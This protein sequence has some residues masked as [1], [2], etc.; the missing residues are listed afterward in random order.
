[1]RMKGW[2]MGAWLMGI[3]AGIAGAESLQTVHLKDYLNR[4]WA[5]ELISY[6]L[7][8]TLAGAK[9]IQVKDETGAALPCQVHNARVYL[10]VTLLPN[11]EKTFTISAGHPPPPPAKP[12]TVK[13]ENGLLVLDSGAMAVRL[14][15]GEASYTEPATPGNVPGPLQGVRGV[16]GDWIGRS[17]LEA[18]FKVTARKTAITVQGSLWSEA[19]IDYTF[20]GNR[21]YRFTLRAIAG[22]PVM[23]IDESMDLNP[24]GHYALLKYDNDSD[25]S[26]WEWWGLADSEHLGVGDMHQEHPA[27]AVFSFSDHLQPNQCRWIAGRPTHPRKGVDAQ[28]K[29]AI[30]EEAGELYAPLTYEQDERFNRLTGWWL[31]SFS[32]RSYVFSM[33]ND[34]NATS[35]VVSLMMGRPS[36]NVNPTTVPPP[37]PWIKIV[38]GLNDMRI[39]TTKAKE[40][41]VLAPICL[42]SR[43]WMLSVL[44]P[45]AMPP[46]DGKTLPPTFR[47]LLKYSYF[48][49][50]KIKDWSFDWPE[51]PSAWPRLFCKAGDMATMRQRVAAASGQMANSAFIPAIYRAN[52]NT[53]AMVKQILPLLETMVRG[54]FCEYGPN[55]EGGHGSINWFHASLGMMQAMPLWEAA[56]ATPGIDPA[57]RAKIKAYGAFV[58]QRAWDDDYWPPK[59]TG[60][61]WGSAN[62]GTLAAGAR[63][64]TAAAMAGHPGQERWLKRCRGYLDGNLQGLL[65][66][67]GSGL[68]CP[69]YLGASA[70]PVLYMAL[71]L[72]YGGNYDVFRRDPRWR[73]FSQFMIDILTPPDL[74][75][76]L[77]GPSSGLP[78]GA[79]LD[80]NARNRRNLWP[81]GHTSRTETSGILDML[82]L[83]MAGVDE[84]LAGAL[85]TMATEQGETSGGAFVAYALLL[86][87]QS[88]PVPPD[89]ASRWYPSY[90]AILR[91]T[92]AAETWLAIRYSKFAFDHFQADMGAFTLFGRGVPLMMDFGSMYSPEDGQPVYHNRVSWDVKEGDPK[93]C[94]GDQKDGC[95]YKGLTYFEHTVE[96]WT[97][98]AE[99]F[100]EGQSPTDSFGDI[101]HFASLP[102]ADYL[103]GETDVRTLQTLPYFPATPAALAPDPNQKRVLE[104]VAPF[105]WKRSVL[106]VKAQLDPQP[107]YVLVRDDFSAPCAPPTFSYWVMASDL[108]FEGNRALATGQFGVDLDLYVAQPAKPALSK[109]QWSHANW[110]GETQVCMRVTQ[111]EGKPCVVLMYP[112]K[113]GE[114]KPEFATLADGNGVKITLPGETHW[115]ISAPMEVTVKDG[116]LSFTGTAC[117][118]K[119]LADGQVKVTLLAPGDVRFGKDVFRS[120]KPA[121]RLL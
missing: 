56:M 108:A 82:A 22:Q 106:F 115:V 33:Y 34:A 19:S 1:M 109:W 36:R 78:L 12:V 81:L 4:T 42:G 111:A 94:P 116:D 65:A 31:N 11:S 119:K 43:E 77:G 13:E 99:S 117:V 88:K 113:A 30:I 32:D 61:G 73:K 75:S 100:G 63:V 55:G 114:P 64:L 53:N 121:S 15:A 92:R 98:K 28:G 110:G 102:E 45:S 101:K 97:C 44:P 25:A 85:R 59:E 71:A 105:T 38:T 76:P 67:D 90:G 47:A 23:I 26:T 35:P 7:D 89:L 54:A 17:W 68:S 24:G 84:K 40:L 10:L 3:A 79:K 50:E 37:Q 49:L 41:K 70:D 112:R 103:E 91:D 16:G 8:K 51:P 58:A 27:N 39:Y 80:P 60:N 87:T 6:P 14:P 69:H 120:K 62:M 72:K 48:P 5:D 74:R 66:E 2:L 21:H 104:N 57:V 86:N 20:E 96:P 9:E 95:F 29:P 93:P 107:S 52:G 118:V 46:R 18:P 83:G